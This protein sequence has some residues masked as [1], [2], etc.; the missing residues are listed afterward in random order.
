MRKTKGKDS[1]GHDGVSNKA[2]KMC[3]SVVD[4]PIPNLFNHWFQLEY[5]PDKMKFAR[6]IPLHKS[7]DIYDVSN[8]R[9]ISLSTSIKNLWKNIIQQKAQIRN[10]KT[11]DLNSRHFEFFPAFLS[12]CSGALTPFIEFVRKCLS[13]RENI[14]TRFINLQKAF[15]KID[16]KFLCAKLHRYGFRGNFLQ[17]IES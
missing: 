16:P 5:Y 6:V 17:F 9:P 4:K 8:Y 13:R 11:K 14:D 1:F 12:F 3:S 15:D 10:R 7:A 2:L